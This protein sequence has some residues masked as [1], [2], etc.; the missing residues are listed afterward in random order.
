MGE[1]NTECSLPN[2]YSVFNRRTEL[3]TWEALSKALAKTIPIGIWQKTIKVMLP[4]MYRFR[5]W[6]EKNGDIQ[7]RSLSSKA[8]QYTRGM[9][10][11]THR[12]CGH[13]RE[14]CCW[15]RGRALPS[16]G[17]QQMQSKSETSSSWP[18]MLAFPITYLSHYPDQGEKAHIF[19]L[20]M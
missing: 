2:L 20:K 19:P 8:N 7:A 15:Q 13:P 18:A 12:G 5:S 16:H 4:N 9:A 10:P 17:S 6:R 3:P 11:Q 14:E 1:Q